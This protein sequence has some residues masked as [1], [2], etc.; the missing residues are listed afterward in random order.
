VLS[1]V[2]VCLVLSTN[3]AAIIFFELSEGQAPTTLLAK[4][5]ASGIPLWLEMIF[6]LSNAQAAE[7]PIFQYFNQLTS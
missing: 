6:D 1:V 7:A 5:V 4:H 3:F 2:I